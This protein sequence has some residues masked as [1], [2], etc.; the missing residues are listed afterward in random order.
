MP[1]CHIQPPFIANISTF[2]YTYVAN[3]QQRCISTACAYASPATRICAMYAIDW[4]IA[5]YILGV[6]TD[7]DVAQ[8]QLL[9]NLR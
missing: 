1:C 8:K 4:R 2:I 3:T 9:P 6:M 5:L 7:G